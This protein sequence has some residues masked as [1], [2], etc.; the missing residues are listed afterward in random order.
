MIFIYEIECTSYAVMVTGS[1]IP[2]INILC[3]ATSTKL[4]ILPS[5]SG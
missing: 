2:A 4:T 1:E 5:I 3:S